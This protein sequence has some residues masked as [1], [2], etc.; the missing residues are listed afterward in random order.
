[1][2]KAVGSIALVVALVASTLALATTAAAAS[3]SP[4][5]SPASISC[6]L[7]GGAQGSISGGDGTSVNTTT[8]STT[9][10]T[11]G[12]SATSTA[13]DALNA[14]ALPDTPADPSTSLTDEMLT[15][16][17]NQGVAE[18]TAIG[19]NVPAITASIEDLPDTQLGSFTGSSI[20]IDRDAAGWGW[21][22]MDL[23]TAVRH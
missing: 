4:S 15:A 6:P 10:T 8:P 16:A 20:V 11:S 23:L 13:S 9:P 14:A 18:W 7:A 1:M 17:L 19:A 3:P 12:T 5:A 2:R 22:A 21:Q